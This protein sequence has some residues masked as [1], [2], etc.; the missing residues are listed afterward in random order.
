MAS[1]RGRAPPPGERPG[2]SEGP[3]LVHQVLPDRGP[4]DGCEDG[5]PGLLP[6]ADMPG[7]QDGV[8]EDLFPEVHTFQDPSP[9]LLGRPQLALE[10]L[11]PL[12]PLCEGLLKRRHLSTVD[13]VPVLRSGKQ[14]GDRVSHLQNPR[15]QAMRSPTRAVDHPLVFSRGKAAAQI[16][17]NRAVRGSSP[18]F[19]STSITGVLDPDPSRRGR[20]TVATS[21]TSTISFSF[22][23]LAARAASC[24][25]LKPAGRVVAKGRPVGTD[26]SALGSA[27]F[28][29]SAFLD[30]RLIFVAGAGG[31]AET[32]K[33]HMVPEE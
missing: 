6:S 4:R 22:P 13:L 14:V 29:G 28:E 26:A 32:G 20:F 15:S 2:S 11:D 5:F 31:R 21:S 8:G 7:E 9:G 24:S 27:G 18:C 10:L 25:L 19:I 17:D 12:L 3:E 23:R 33:L 16:L 30:P 1:G